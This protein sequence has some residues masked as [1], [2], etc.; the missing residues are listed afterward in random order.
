MNSLNCAL[1]CVWKMTSY[2]KFLPPGFLCYP[3][4]D[5]Q[6]PGT[7]GQINCVSFKLLSAQQQEMKVRP[8]LCWFQI[9]NS[10]TGSSVKFSVAQLQLFC[11]CEIVS[12]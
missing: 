11:K 8:A 3:G 6:Y 1:N 9:G 12:Q 4:T 5:G 10:L 2:F 7:T